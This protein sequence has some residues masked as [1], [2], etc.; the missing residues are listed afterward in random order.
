MLDFFPLQRGMGDNKAMVS[1]VVSGILSTVGVVFVLFK[2]FVLHLFYSFISSQST[3]EKESSFIYK[4]VNRG[5]SLIA[6]LTLI[7]NSDI[8]LLLSTCSTISLTWMFFLGN[9]TMLH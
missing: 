6:S 4:K 5:W 9:D 7:R 8:V 3:I 1:W 2:S